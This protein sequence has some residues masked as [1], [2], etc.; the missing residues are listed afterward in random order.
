MIGGFIVSAI[1]L[2]VFVLVERRV[3]KPLIQYAVEEAVAA[4]TAASPLA[5]DDPRAVGTRTELG[6][7][8]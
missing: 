4:G 1:F 6:L 5:R 2:V 7:I 3:D 8:H